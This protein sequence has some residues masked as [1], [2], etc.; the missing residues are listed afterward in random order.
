MTTI[1]CILDTNMRGNATDTGRIDYRYLPKMGYHVITIIIISTC[2]RCV[3][4]PSF[5][6]GQRIIDAYTPRLWHGTLQRDA[7]QDCNPLYVRRFLAEDNRN[8]NTIRSD[9]T[10]G[11]RNYFILESRCAD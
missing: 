5:I 6:Q 10:P 7:Q 1:T 3:Y 8:D 11:N 9:N 4:M 2:I